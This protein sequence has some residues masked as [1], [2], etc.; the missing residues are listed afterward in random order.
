VDIAFSSYQITVS[1]SA[2]SLTIGLNGGNRVTYASMT[3]TT[4]ASMPTSP[5]YTTVTK[6]NK[7]IQRTSVSGYGMTFKDYGTY[8]ETRGQAVVNT[9]HPR[10][11]LPAAFA[12]QITE[13]LRQNTA[14]MITSGT[15]TLASR[16][17]T[18]SSSATVQFGQSCKGTT[19][20]VSIERFLGDVSQGSV[21]MSWSD[22]SQL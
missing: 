2:D 12:W 16:N 10:F 13:P 19:T 22:F 9:S 6:F 14:G 5:V 18:P 17:L 20:C 3:E 1:D 21:T 11:S 15:L 4:V 8:T 7:V